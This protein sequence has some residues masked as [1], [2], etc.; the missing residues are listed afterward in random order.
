MTQQ[1]AYHRPLVMLFLLSLQCHVDL[2]QVSP[3]VGQARSHYYVLSITQGCHRQSC[4]V[5][6]GTRASC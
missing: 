5:R 3:T 2:C 6:S 1:G 4:Q